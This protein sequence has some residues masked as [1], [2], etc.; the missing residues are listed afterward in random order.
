MSFVSFHTLAPPSPR[1]KLEGTSAEKFPYGWRNIIETLPSGQEVYYQ[2]PLTQA[3]FLNP[4]MG[5]QLVQ[6]IKHSRCGIDLFNRL[7]NYYAND[8]TVGVFFDVKVEWGIPGLIEPAPDVCVVPHLTE[9]EPDVGTFK[10]SDWGTRP[11]LIIEVMSPQYPGDD[12]TKVEVYEQAAVPEYI[13][14][15]PYST[16]NKKKLSYSLMGYRLVK[17]RYQAI[18]PDKQGRLL[19][20]TT[21]VLFEVSKNRQSVILTNA[22]TGAPLLTASEEKVSREKAEILAQ[23]ALKQAQVAESQAQ[24]AQQEVQLALVRVEAEA[25]ARQEAQ[26]RAAAEAKARQEA[27]ARAVAAAKIR[28]ELERRLRELESQVGLKRD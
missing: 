6:R 17:G 13:L 16:K 24:Q 23:Q 25:Q 10:V 2:V 1:V 21:G 26:A 11:C 18:L 22:A 9:K 20:Q 4:Q 19:S 27:E 12:T 5:D 7:D 14:V 15:N 3:D 28:A 8:P